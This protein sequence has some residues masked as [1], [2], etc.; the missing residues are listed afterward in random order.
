MAN[1]RSA[2]PRALATLLNGHNKLFINTLEGL[3]LVLERWNFD[4]HLSHA[5]AEHEQML[6]EA[7][8]IVGRQ[9]TA[10]DLRTELRTAGETQLAKQVSESN[11]VRRVAAHPRLGLRRK[12]CSALNKNQHDEDLETDASR[13]FEIHDALHAEAPPASDVA[14]RKWHSLVARAVCVVGEE[15]MKSAVEHR[16]DFAAQEA[17]DTIDLENAHWEPFLPLVGRVV[18]A[19]SKLVSSDHFPTIVPKGSLGYVREV[20]EDGDVLVIID[21]GRCA[22]IHV[23]LENK[24]FSTLESLKRLSSPYDD[25]LA[26]GGG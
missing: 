1:P 6:E 22:N 13:T 2:P 17:F 12:V 23:W 7:G 3:A 25:C 5:M 10:G 4:S 16:H 14:A 15:R 21:G 20:D 8:D 18:R 11:V 24:Q 26:A 9:L 19:N